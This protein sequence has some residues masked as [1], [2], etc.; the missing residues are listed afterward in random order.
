MYIT[1]ISISIIIFFPKNGFH[2]FMIKV[3][4]N[5][6]IKQIFEFTP[7]GK[8]RTRVPYE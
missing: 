3:N 1:F 8:D 7:D 5:L 4:A 6:F 2:I